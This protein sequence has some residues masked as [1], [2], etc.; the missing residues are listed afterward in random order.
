LEGPYRDL[1][2][3]FAR[4]TGPEGARRNPSRLRYVED[5]LA[6]LVR[7]A[8]DAGAANI[9]V[10]STLKRRRYRTL[11]VIDDGAGVP[12]THRDLIF[13]PGVTSRHLRPVAHPDDGGTPHGAGLS[14]YYLKAAAVSAELLSAS[15]PTAITATFDTRTLPER[16]LQSGS[17][18]SHSNLRA[19][20]QRFAAKPS[21]PT[22]Y[23]GSPARILATLL[24]NRIIH[25]GES[26]SELLEAA[27]GLGLAIS[28]RT[29]QRVW[30]GDVSPAAA[31]EAPHVGGPGEEHRAPKAGGDG[32]SL[33]LGEEEWG[34]IAAI[35]RR[36]ARASYLEL[37]D[38]ELESRPGEISLRAS[39]YEPEEDYE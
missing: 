36:A 18:P 6:E 28:L 8:R 14:L 33:S 31:V 20:L 22:H 11:T 17:R 32:P 1:G 21:G 16:A 2:S 15:S 25:P 23:L 5:A 9:Y 27:E 3:G 7:N 13:E 26:A 39:V 38:L 34:E 10:A 24:F 30:R 37:G 4:L 12:E 19:T 35:L 29:A